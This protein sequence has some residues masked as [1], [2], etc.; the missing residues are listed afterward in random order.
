[1]HLSSFPLSLRRHFG[2]FKPTLLSYPFFRGRYMMLQN[3]RA[4]V[5][6]KEPHFEVIGEERVYN[7]WRKVTRRDIIMPSGIK[8]SF[9]IFSQDAPCVVVFTW[10]TRTRTTTLVQEFYPGPQKLMLGAVGGVYEPKKHRTVL[11]CAQYELE[12]EAQLRSD[13]WISLL[14]KDSKGMPFDKYSDNILF[15]YLAIDCE[16][17]TNP[18]PIDT[19]E[20]IAVERNVSYARV[21]ALLAS[22]QLALPT[23][24]AV[25]MASN[26]LRELGLPLE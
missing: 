6:S 16:T 23:A 4:M 7:G 21:M 1:M 10:D 5:D 14:D 13:K 19:T 20:W 24:Y 11:E 15:P 3:T 12:E 22:G 2:C 25:L 8:A 17:V 18:K 9:D 26:K